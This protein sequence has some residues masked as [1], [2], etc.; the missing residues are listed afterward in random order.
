MLLRLAVAVV[1][2][3]LVILLF[4]FLHPVFL[5]VGLSVVSAL[6][7]FELIYSTGYLKDI[8]VLV[9]SMLFAAALPTWIY[10]GERG[11]FLDLGLFLF[12]LIVFALCMARKKQADPK[13]IFFAFTASFLLPY[14]LS[15]II[16]LVRDYPPIV[17]LFPLAIAWFTDAMAFFV[18]IAFGRHKLAPRI[19]PKKTVEGFAG[20]MLGGILAAVGIGIAGQL[21]FDLTPQFFLLIPIGIV[22]SLV[23]QMG[24]LAFSFIKRSVGV[25][26]FGSVM[27]GHGGI[28]DRFDSLLF[29]APYVSICMAFLGKLFYV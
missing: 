7:A 4:F 2:V 21:Y 28:L 29:V 19:S 5:L 23:A 11:D 1:G 15:E 9:V 13:N 24:D 12:V 10:L 22:G 8:P 20:G 14:F 17:A 25:K 27:P 3:P 16:V 26:D 18:G 6:T